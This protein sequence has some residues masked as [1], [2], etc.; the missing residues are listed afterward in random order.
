MIHTLTSLQ[1]DSVA[2]EISLGLVLLVMVVVVFL[3]GVLVMYAF[4]IGKTRPGYF[5]QRLRTSRKKHDT[6]LDVDVWKESGRRLKV[7][8]DEVGDQA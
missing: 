2:R 1:S 5:A 3:I 8:D 7:V 6:G 4:G